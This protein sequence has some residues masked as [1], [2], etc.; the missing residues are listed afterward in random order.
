ML[1]DWKMQLYWHLPIRI[2][3]AALSLYAKHL[4]KIYYNHIYEEWKQWLSGWKN[5][6]PEYIKEWKEQRLQHIIETAAKHVPY[7]H[8]QWKDRNWK[9]IHTEA[10]LHLIPT[11]E[12]QSLRRNEHAFITNGAKPKS[13]WLEK[14]SGTTGTSLKI[15]WP[16]LMVPQWYAVT[17]VMVRNIAGVEQETPRAMI[18]GRPIIPGD[19]KKPPYWRFNRRWKQLYFSSYHISQKTVAEYVEA[20]KKYESQWMTGYGSAIATLAE[21]ALDDGINP[22]PIEA[23]IVSGDTLLR[24]MRQS[25]EQFFKCKCF[26]S[27]GQCEGVSMAME[28]LYGQ[29]HIIP[30]VGITEILREDGTPCESGET[31]EIVAT[32]LLNDA[33]PLIRYRTGDYAAWA[34]DQCCPCGNPNPIITNLIG[35]TDDYLITADGRKV[36]RLS[37]A[38]KRS[39]TIHSAQIV[40][41]K[42]DHAFLLVRPGENYRLSH[43]EAIRDDILERIGKFDIEIIEVPEIPKTPQGKTVLVVRLDERPVMKEMYKKLI[44]RIDI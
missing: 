33:M 6:T 34:E 11:L 10:D 9:S 43:A 35:R 39:P 12:K 14:T 41:D 18:G 27:Y 21:S 23:V 5:W 17:E 42:P 16:M 8:N 44:K 26:D 29:M 32:S 15:Y 3:E 4:E 38:M 1:N 25:I 36:G 30:V 22:Y 31:G 7:Y 40:Q 37:T 13:L 24:G 19:T 2:Q 20:L 28:C